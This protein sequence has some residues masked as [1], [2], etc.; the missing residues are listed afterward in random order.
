MNTIAPEKF[1]WI[2]VAVMVAI[3]IGLL[4]YI[5][6]G[7]NKR[8]TR[9]LQSKE[10]RKERLIAYFQENIGL[11]QKQSD[12]FSE[13]WEAFH[14]EAQADRQANMQLRDQLHHAIASPD[15][16]Q[17]VVDSLLQLTTS[18]VIAH[19]RI[20]M[21]HFDKLFAV[22]TPE[23]RE[24]LGEAFTK[25]MAKGPGMERERPRPERPDRAPRQ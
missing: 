14:V 19:E 22:C 25:M 20:V 13:L 9:P 23:Q 10:Q 6:M 24:K 17:R 12:E 4:G 1:S 8:Q 21:E 2:V 3:N 15:R 18:K 7:E 16:D 11:D 5:V